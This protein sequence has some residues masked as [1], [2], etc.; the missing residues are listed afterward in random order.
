M[1]KGLRFVLLLSVLASAVLLPSPKPVYALISCDSI[2]G[3]HCQ[4]LSKPI[5]CVNSD[6]SA[7][8][9]FCENKHWVCS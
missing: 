5:A 1:N 2:S 6:G 7:G 9:C 8:T 4:N 3:G